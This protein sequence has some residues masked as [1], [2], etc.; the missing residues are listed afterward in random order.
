[1]GVKAQQ[2]RGS[3]VFYSLGLG[4][5]ERISRQSRSPENGGVQ[6]SHGEKD[7]RSFFAL[8][9]H[10]IYPCEHH[11]LPTTH[12]EIAH[13]TEQDSTL[14]ITLLHTSCGFL[15]DRSRMQV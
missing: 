3:R 5:D 2:R 15:S 7:K 13:S 11:T 9:F 6:S 10:L 8:R 1:M 14:A 12:P 4:Q